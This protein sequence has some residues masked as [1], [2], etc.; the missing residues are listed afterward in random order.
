VLS[1][2]PDGSQILTWT[3]QANITNGT[4]DENFTPNIV[5]KTA[6]LRKG[7]RVPGIPPSCADVN[8]PTCYLPMIRLDVGDFRC[9]STSSSG[10]PSFTVPM[11]ENMS[12]G[13]RVT[14]T[15]DFGTFQAVAVDDADLLLWKAQVNVPAASVFVT[16]RDNVSLELDLTAMGSTGTG[17][18]AL[19]ADPPSGD[20]GLIRESASS[21][22]QPVFTLTS[23]GW[24]PV[25]VQ[26]IT[27]TGT[28]AAEF[29]SLSASRLILRAAPPGG[30]GLVSPRPPRSGAALGT[31]ASN[32]PSLIETRVPVAVPFFLDSGTQAEIDVTPSFKTAGLKQAQLVITFADV[33]GIPETLTLPIEANSVTPEVTV[34][35]Q[36]LH[37]QLT[38]SANSGTAVQRAALFANDGIPP[39]VRKSAAIAGPDSQDFMLVESQYGLAASDPTQPLT[40]PSGQSEV[41]RVG[42]HPSAAGDRQAVLTISSDAGNF[43]IPLL[44]HCDGTCRQP[45]PAP[46]YHVKTPQLGPAEVLPQ[47]VR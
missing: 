16:Q 5:V 26:R 7:P 46:T 8:A 42:F 6:R 12:G 38:W 32:P 11:C 30:S 14:P 21:G 28:D 25:Q 2:K 33:R 41:Y 27:L 36:E 43:T 24:L 45:P 15:Y 39:I 1:T 3:F 47:I 4:W 13:L 17:R 34:A 35:P 20:L 10:D 22:A 18:G 19:R 23:V 31:P 37:F 44:G 9:V 29:G 40:I